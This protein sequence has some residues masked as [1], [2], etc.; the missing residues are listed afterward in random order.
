M[1]GLL[2]LCTSLCY[3]AGGEEQGDGDNK[4]LR[5][6]DLSAGRQAL[7]PA[8]VSGLG[9]EELLN[10]R[11]PVPDDSNCN[12]SVWQTFEGLQKSSKLQSASAIL[13]LSPPHSPRLWRPDSD[14]QAPAVEASDTVLSDY[15]SFASDTV[16]SGYVSFAGEFKIPELDPEAQTPSDIPIDYI[17]LQ[18]LKDRLLSD[19]D[20]GVQ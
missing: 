14:E 12:T 15:V 17:P 8:I 11:H 4:E 5:D 6:M 16:L 3:V 19:E 2:I 18:K 1:P 13:S 10:S 20:D 7:D 9:D